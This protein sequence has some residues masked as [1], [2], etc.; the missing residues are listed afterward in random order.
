MNQFLLD[1]IKDNFKQ[2]GSALDLGC[3]K[4]EDVKGLKELGWKATGVDLPEVDLNYFYKVTDKLDLIYSNYVLQFIK[5]KE[6]FIETCY[7]NL[8]DGGFLFIATF[9]KSDEVLKNT[10][11]EQEL[12]DFF[13]NKFR[14]IK[15][16]KVGVGDNHPP[17][18]Q[19]KHVV[20][21]LTAQK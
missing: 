6:A 11:T 18:G 1:F 13:K 3:G 9:D 15:I 12:F 19:H 4:G 2:A 16:E 21:M 14:N 20:L 7:A 17:I 10:F 8:K 5:N